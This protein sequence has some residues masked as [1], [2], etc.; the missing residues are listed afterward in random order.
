[1]DG[2]NLYGLYIGLTRLDPAGES[3]LGYACRCLGMTGYPDYIVQMQEDVRK[4]VENRDAFVGDD[5]SYESKL[6]GLRDR[7]WKFSSEFKSGY[8]EGF[9]IVAIQ[10]LQSILNVNETETEKLSVLTM[11]QRAA[12]LSGLN[13]KLPTHE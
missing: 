4:F 10:A 7:H 13:E 12:I 5:D 3:V 9:Q 8:H 2:P 1:V 6:K 11:E